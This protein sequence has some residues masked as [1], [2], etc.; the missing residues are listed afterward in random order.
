MLAPENVR[1]AY[2]QG[3]EISFWTAPDGW[4]LRRFDWPSATTPPRGSILFQA[5]R[6]DLFE[7]YLEACGH[8]HDRG[9]DI[10]GFDWRGQGGSRDLGRGLEPDDRLSFDPLIDDLAA[11]VADWQRR[12]EGP[13]VLVAHSMGGHV[14]LRM[15]AERGVALDALVLV[16]PM[17]ALNTRFL[18]PLLTSALVG[19]ASLKASDFLAIAAGCP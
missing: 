16:A 2:P 11:Y 18:P 3:S 14:A 19:G 15:F 17:L 8:W 5:G 12:T 4:R 10:E 13:H 7:K 6:G 1:R 9:W